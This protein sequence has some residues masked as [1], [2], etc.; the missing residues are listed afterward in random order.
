MDADAA[1]ALASVLSRDRD[2]Y[3]SFERSQQA[4]MNS[5]SSVA[6]Y[7]V[8]TASE[9]CSHPPRLFTRR[10]VTDG[11]DTPV[12]AMTSTEALW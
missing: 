3:R 7:G 10:L 12:D 1:L 9:Y 5:G 2:I 4:P 8:M 11:V 6:Q